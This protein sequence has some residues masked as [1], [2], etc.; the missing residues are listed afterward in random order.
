[1]R[2]AQRKEF[3]PEGEDLLLNPIALRA[4]KTQWRFGYS[5]YNSVK[6]P[7]LD[8]IKCRGMQT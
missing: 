8:G 5:E 6:D 1:M 3:I 7:V 2:S 4:A